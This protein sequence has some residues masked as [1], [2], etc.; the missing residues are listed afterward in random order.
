MHGAQIEK[1]FNFLPASKMAIPSNYL[2]STP[3]VATGKVCMVC[4]SS[5]SKMVRGCSEEFDTSVE[6]I[7]CPADF[8]TGKIWS[9][10][11]LV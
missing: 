6:D 11:W 8:L 5:S 9:L 3:I 7:V 4:H 10:V 2:Y 1:A